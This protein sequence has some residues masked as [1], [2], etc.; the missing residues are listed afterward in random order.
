MV[1]AHTQADLDRAL[2]HVAHGEQLVREQRARLAR[3]HIAGLETEE[4][5]RFLRIM[6]VTLEQFRWHA[7][8]IA[9]DVKPL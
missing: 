8:E 9:K 1:M 6:E 5:R 7:R 2:R 4:A 3:R